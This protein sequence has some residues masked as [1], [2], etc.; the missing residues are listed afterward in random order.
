[1]NIFLTLKCGFNDSFYFI[2]QFS[3]LNNIQKVFV[4]RDEKSLELE[5][6]HYILP[7]GIRKSFFRLIIRFFQML[8]Y[9]PK[10]GLIVGIYELPHGLLA[11]LVGKLRHV[12]CAVSI[13]S[14][15]AYT[16]LRKGI[17]LKITLYLLKTCDFV[18]VTG[19]NSRNYLIQQGIRAK[20]IY[21]L[22]N[23]LD[24]SAFRKLSIKKEYDIISVGRI[25]EEKRI[26]V[27]VKIVLQLKKSIPNIKV[28]IAG[29][30]PKKDEIQGLITNL[31]L[32]KNIDV[33]GYI[34]PDEKLCEYFNKGKVFVLT[35]ETEGFPRTIIQAAACGLPVV[36][37]NVGDIEDIVD[38][39]MNGF[40]V[41][42]Y[43]N[44][45][46]YCKNIIELLNNEKLYK[47]FSMVL[48]NKVRDSF[49][50]ERAENVWQKIID[51]IGK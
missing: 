1:M 26:E 47:K 14:N 17:R 50:S 48:D 12:P 36:A 22:P 34:E 51:E 29:T 44:I 5:N 18:T 6:V 41:N 19:N 45:D 39:N 8:F 20:K 49:I 16:Q 11:V 31:N 35:S 2:Q 38:H 27:L 21:V 30:G 40:L 37:S 42:D 9:A 7:G 24:F 10:P 32:M 23:T 3:F 15:P 33:Y 46:E 25:S 28:A 13:I 4:F 43:K